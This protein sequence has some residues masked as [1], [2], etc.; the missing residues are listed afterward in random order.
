MTLMPYAPPPA[1]RARRAEA[2]EASQPRP[3]P[4]FEFDGV[5]PSVVTSHERKG[6]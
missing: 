6:M 4:G 2:N 1:V 5:M 3:F